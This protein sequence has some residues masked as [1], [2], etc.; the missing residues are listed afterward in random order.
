[1]PFLLLL[2]VTSF[3]GARVLVE[4]NGI[5][6]LDSEAVINVPV[7]I[8]GFLVLALVVPWLG[9]VLSSTVLLAVLS[10]FY[11]NR[12]LI[13][14]AVCWRRRLYCA[15]AVDNRGTGDKARTLA[16]VRDE[17]VVGSPPTCKSLG[18]PC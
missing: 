13:A 8:L 1:L 2:S 18:F 12:N 16:C 9:F 11:G 6:N 5:R 17:R 4:E 15:V 7:T 14:C 3:Y 10:T